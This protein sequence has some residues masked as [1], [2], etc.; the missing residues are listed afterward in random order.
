MS[1]PSWKNG[2]PRNVTSPTITLASSNSGR[3]LTAC[4]KVA[5]AA[6]ADSNASGAPGREV[7]GQLGPSRGPRPSRL[8]N[9]SRILHRTQEPARVSAAG[10]TPFA[11]SSLAFVAA[12]AL[13][14]NES[15]MTASTLGPR[16]VDAKRGTRLVGVELVV[17]FG[18]HRAPWAGQRGRRP[19]HWRTRRWGVPPPSATAVRG[20]HGAHRAERSD[21]FEIRGS[22]RDRDHL[23]ARADRE[24]LGSGAPKRLEC[25]RLAP[26]TT[27]RAV[28]TIRPP[29]ENQASRPVRRQRLRRL[30]WTAGVMLTR[31][32]ASRES[33]EAGG[34]L[35]RSP[36]H[37][38]WLQQRCLAAPA[39]ASKSTASAVINHGKGATNEPWPAA[40]SAKRP[41]RSSRGEDSML[42]TLKPTI[43]GLLSVRSSLRWI[44]WRNSLTEWGGGGF[45]GQRLL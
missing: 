18:A 45:E 22:H 25:R 3:A 7:S 31:A 1:G 19:R 14:S 16:A 26:W 37:R 15:E 4:G 9:R 40:N 39:A 32:P 12:L 35:R 41:G 11:T 13:V 29:S 42:P 38:A 10:E 5:V 20:Q 43:A 28:T 30:A 8:E 36:G 2:S 24:D 23:I 33:L 34:E 21:P 6:D 27:S 44:S 17:A